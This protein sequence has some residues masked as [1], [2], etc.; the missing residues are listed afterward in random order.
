MGFIIE[1][2]KTEESIKNGSRYGRCK[3][4]CSLGQSKLWAFYSMSRQLQENQENGGITLDTLYRNN[5]NFLE[6]RTIP[7]LM[8]SVDAK[9]K[10]FNQVHYLEQHIY[11][12]RTKTDSTDNYLR[13]RTDFQYN[14]KHHEY[15]DE[16]QATFF[17]SETLFERTRDSLTFMNYAFKVGVEYQKSSHF[18]GLLATYAQNDLFYK[19]LVKPEYQSLLENN[20]LHLKNTGLELIYN[21][22]PQDN[23]WNARTSYQRILS[24]EYKQN[25]KLEFQLGFRWGDGIQASLNG[26][27]IETHP[28]VKKLLYR[29]NYLSHNWTNKDDFSRL[30]IQ[31]IGLNFQSGQEFRL[32]LKHQ[33]IENYTYYQIDFTPTQYSKP[34]GYTNLEIESKFVG[35]LFGWDQRL[36]FQHLSISDPSVIDLPK[37]TIR[38]NWFYND[39]FFDSALYGRAGIE[40]NYLTSFYGPTYIPTL[41]EF[42]GQQNIQIGNS[43]SVDPYISFKVKTM[44]IYIK[45]QNVLSGL[46]RRLRDNLEDNKPVFPYNHY[47]TVGYPWVDDEIR[48]GIVWYF[49]K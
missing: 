7:T 17:G 42:A 23:W 45:Y 36:L 14:R 25:S 8:D 18:V 30:E 6:R 9:T 34:I 20:R 32:S 15:M 22:L 1:G 29:S 11:L 28:E 24:G 40:L 3:Y 27:L 33:Q 4:I 16:R 43:Y 12:D 26:S 31:S 2:S 35:K 13:L 48:F 21:F 47:A 38:S 46:N 5:M 49:F 39:W 44:K 37:F 10:Y 41:A 19:D